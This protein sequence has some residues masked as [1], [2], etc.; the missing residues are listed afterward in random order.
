MELTL[1]D[2][3]LAGVIDVSTVD[4]KKAKT[5]KEER[6][7][8]GDDG[9]WYLTVRGSLAEPKKIQILDKEKREFSNRTGIDAP[10]KA[11]FSPTVFH[12]TDTPDAVMDFGTTKILGELIKAKT[13]DLTDT[14]EW[15]QFMDSYKKYFLMT[16]NMQNS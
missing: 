14:D 4:Q 15:N 8:Q 3:N 16:V 11:L 12:A 13:S 9:E 1:A 2:M 10:F 6:V 5:L 7:Y